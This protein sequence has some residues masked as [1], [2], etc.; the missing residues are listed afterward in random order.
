MN[1]DRTGVDRLRS[2]I[3]E[4][5]STLGPPAERAGRGLRAAAAVAA[6]GA[7]AIL[8]TAVWIARG[9]APG[10]AI[11]SPRPGVEVRELRLHGQ[12][13]GVRVFDATRAGTIVV[14]PVE[15]ARTGE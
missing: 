11:V 8:A 5:A 2:A 6:I 4:V 15:R 13:V 12:E 14:T 9:R 10:D 1:D 3:D 7:L